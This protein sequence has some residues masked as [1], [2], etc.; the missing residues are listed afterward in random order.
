MTD[1]DK[2]NIIDQRY[3][4]DAELRYYMGNSRPRTYAQWLDYFGE[5]YS[6]YE[7]A[8]PSAPAANGGPPRSSA[9]MTSYSAG[10]RLNC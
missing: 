6:K 9:S 8:V 1:P 5:H 3:A 2:R 10:L 4:S 7:V